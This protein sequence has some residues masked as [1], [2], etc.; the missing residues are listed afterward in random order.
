[1]AAS[2]KGS[3]LLD[4]IAP[5]SGPSGFHAQLSGANLSDLIQMECMT[6]A[7]RV[8]RVT[9]RGNIG[10]LYFR[11]GHVGHASTLDLDGEAAALDM[12]TWDQGTFEVTER[13]WPPM[14][15]IRTPWQGLLLKA[16]QR[17]DDA[18]HGK[19]VAFPQKERSS[20]RPE[21]PSSSEWLVP[22]TEVDVDVHMKANEKPSLESDEFELSVRLSANGAVL[23]SNG[24]PEADV[25]DFAGMVAY[26]SRLAELVG[27]L[28][29]VDGFQAMDVVFKQGQCV[30]YKE[31]GELVGLKL[32]PK[33]DVAALRAKLGL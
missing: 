27:E 21:G 16:A 7:R 4:S 5:K 14:D 12:L 17:H 20:V 2:L 15:T 11:D 18:R 30:M 13:D 22:E 26:A 29:G 8:V 19:L 31:D 1:M 24:A 6:R 3:D 9:T 25:E 32:G 33:A 23:F 28:I 10:Y